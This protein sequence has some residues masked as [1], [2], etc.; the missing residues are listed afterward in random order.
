MASDDG[1]SDGTDETL[2]SFRASIDNIDAA[3]V[4]LLAERFKITRAVGEHKARTGMPAADPKREQDQLA[5]LRQMATD[6]ELDPA[7]SEKFQRFIF[8]QVIRHHEHIAHEHTA[9]EHPAH[10]HPAHEEHS[11]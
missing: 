4:R 11:S 1:T 6:A 8:E 2:R 9:H 5:R 10:E 7:I 3:L